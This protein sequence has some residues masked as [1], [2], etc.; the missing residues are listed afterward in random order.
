MVKTALAAAVLL[1]LVAPGVSAD[2]VSN[3]ISWAPSYAE[4][5]AQAKTTNRHLVVDFYTP[6]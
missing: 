4:G 5:L 3:S 2:A 1:L 6:T